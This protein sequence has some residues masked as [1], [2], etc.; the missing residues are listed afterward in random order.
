MGEGLKA[1]NPQPGKFYPIVLVQGQEWIDRDAVV[2]QLTD[3]RTG[4][5][6][7]LEPFLLRKG[8]KLRWAWM[9]IVCRTHDGD[10]GGNLDEAFSD[11]LDHEMDRPLAEWLANTELVKKIRAI[12]EQRKATDVVV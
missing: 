2:H 10:H 9:E 8:E 4:W 3:M 11:W 5:L 6:E 1:F 7:C 12:L